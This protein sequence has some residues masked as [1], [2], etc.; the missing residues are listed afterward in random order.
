ML[1]NAYYS[2]ISPEMC[3]QILYRDSKQAEAASTCLRMTAGDLVGLG[4]VDEV[5]PEPLGGAHCDRNAVLASVG[6]AVK[7]SLDLL[8]AT[9]ASELVERR[10]ERLRAIGEFCTLD[11]R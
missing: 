4:I 3:A 11:E 9:P 1:E 10:Y 8:T 5:L 6:E 2:V 7:R